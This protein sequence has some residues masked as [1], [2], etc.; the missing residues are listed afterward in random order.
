MMN[1]YSLSLWGPL[2]SP[3]P[4]SPRGFYT[5]SPSC[6]KA[7]E[8]LA[9]GGGSEV[10][11]VK[12]DAR[13][14][15]QQVEDLLT[16]RIFHLEEASLETPRRVCSDSGLRVEGA[17]FC[18]FSPKLWECQQKREPPCRAAQDGRVGSSPVLG[19]LRI[20][21]VTSHPASWPLS[22]FPQMRAPTYRKTD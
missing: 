14:K 6:S 15:V 11:R 9:E 21:F 10:Q 5:F 20:E 12:E 19:A 8:S 17:R 7:V 18:S 2:K 16:K 1:K 22:S 4:L 13:K 3:S